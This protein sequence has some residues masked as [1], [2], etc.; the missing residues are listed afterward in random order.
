MTQRWPS[1][2][3]LED[4]FQRRSIAAS[5]TATQSS[6]SRTPMRFRAQPS[7]PDA[8]SCL[9]YHK[10]G[11]AYPIR[12]AREGVRGLIGDIGRCQ[13]LDLS[14]GPPRQSL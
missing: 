2:H 10:S 9:V 6:G 8:P 5:L 11:S 14:H 4:L 13:L 7:A 1:V 12:S 3:R